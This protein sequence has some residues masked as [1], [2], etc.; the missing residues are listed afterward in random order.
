MYV[1]CNSCIS[2][3]NKETVGLSEDQSDHAAEFDPSSLNECQNN[4]KTEQS[5]DE[6]VC[7]SEL[8]A[9]DLNKNWFHVKM[10]QDEDFQGF[11]VPEEEDTV[12][13]KQGSQL[14]GKLVMD[15]KKPFNDIIF[16]KW[17]FLL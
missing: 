8:C 15:L 16:H 2:D 12:D 10:E 1:W 4:I 3:T 5:G 11:C 9:S 6:N 7:N 17:M 14:S 13:I